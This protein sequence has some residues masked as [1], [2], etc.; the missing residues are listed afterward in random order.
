MLVK[1]AWPVKH[2]VVFHVSNGVCVLEFFVACFILLRIPFDGFCFFFFRQVVE[3]QLRTT[4]HTPKGHMSSF[5]IDNQ[6]AQT[7]LS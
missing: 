4:S 2:S 6:P 1:G 3:V 7:F 5:H